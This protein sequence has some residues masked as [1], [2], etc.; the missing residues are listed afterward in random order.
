MDLS[1]IGIDFG[2]DDNRDYQ[3]DSDEQPDSSESVTQASLHSHVKHAILLS[4]TK[5]EEQPHVNAELERLR[6]IFFDAMQ[7]F[8]KEPS[9]PEAKIEGL[10]ALRMLRARAF[11]HLHILRQFHKMVAEDL[12]KTAVEQSSIE[13]SEA[14]LAFAFDEGALDTIENT[15]YEV[16][17]I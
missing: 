2:R 4:K 12:A 11:A 6:P 17:L 16:R 10:S 7:A 5:L 9:N 8:L 14:A 1:S 3:T 15:L 13:A